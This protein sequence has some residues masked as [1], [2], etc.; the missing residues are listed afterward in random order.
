MS[1]QRCIRF[2]KWKWMTIKTYANH[3]NVK[4]EVK[5]EG[6]NKKEQKMKD[7]E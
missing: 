6:E 7:D 5:I 2:Y 4:N 1:E 3:G